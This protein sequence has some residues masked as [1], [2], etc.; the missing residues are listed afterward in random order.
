MTQDF[1]RHFTLNTPDQIVVLLNVSLNY[2]SCLDCL[3]R[4]LSYGF[5]SCC[6]QLSV[7]IAGRST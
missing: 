2:I 6:S 3:P 5:A 1:Q 7:N 4:S